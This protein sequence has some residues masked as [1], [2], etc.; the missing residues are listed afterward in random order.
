MLEC[1]ANFTPAG[2]SIR[3]RIEKAPTAPDGPQGDLVVT[4]PQERGGKF[5]PGNMLL[6]L[7]VVAA[8]GR[9][10]AALG[11]IQFKLG[12]VNRDPEPGRVR[13][14]VSQKSR[15]SEHWPAPGTVSSVN[16]I[17]R[18]FIWSQRPLEPLPAQ[19]SNGP[20][21]R[22]G[23]LFEAWIAQRKTPCQGCQIAARTRSIGFAREQIR[24]RCCRLGRF[25]R[26]YCYRPPQGLS[27][28]TSMRLPPP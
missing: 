7:G 8:Q 18:V 26:A 14:W 21:S 23:Q 25:A 20:G 27:L 11:Q 6:G 4:E 1:G 3:R 24:R 13:G 2:A 15:I 28:P 10:A 17:G 16:P 19:S 9:I 5:H 22:Q 12:S